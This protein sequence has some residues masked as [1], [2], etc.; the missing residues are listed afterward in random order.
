MVK[1]VQ[2]TENPFASVDMAGARKTE[3]RT[4][5]A[6]LCYRFKKGQLQ[7]LLVT[8]RRTKRWILPK[9]WPLD[10]AS[11]AQGAAREAYEEAGVKGRVY[12]AN[13]GAFTYT[14]RLAGG[15]KMPCAVLIYPLHVTKVLTE[16]PEKSER[17]RK[18][19]SPK[20]AAKFVTEPELAHL[21]RHFDP[22][23]FASS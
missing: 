9:G 11:P 10:G 13:L 21:L 14:K 5:F 8:S 20:K 22:R 12:D 18:W 16:Y 15:R 6:A 4:Q 19:M 17:T 1:Q 23:L 2:L 7:V 3:L